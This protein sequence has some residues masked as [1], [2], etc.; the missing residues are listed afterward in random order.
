MPRQHVFRP[1][2]A[3]CLSAIAL[4]AGCSGQSPLQVKTTNPLE[5]DERDVLFAGRGCDV[6]CAAQGGSP[7]IVDR[8]GTGVAWP[9]GGYGGVAGFVPTPGLSGTAGARSVPPR[10][11]ICGDGVVNGLEA[12]DRYD[13][14]GATC[15]SLGYAGGGLL[16]CSPS[17]CNYDVSMCLSQPNFGIPP[18]PVDAGF[19]DDAGVAQQGL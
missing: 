14:S 4:V 1:T 9:V 17:T 5:H 8:A 15:A 19:E 2:L 12:C 13:L 16:R 6:G 11:T 18:L 3:H 7:V 10:Q